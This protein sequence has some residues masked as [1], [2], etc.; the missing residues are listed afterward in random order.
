MP[1]NFL[2]VEFHE[3]SRRRYDL[4]FD[5]A[6]QIRRPL[7]KDENRGEKDTSECDKRRQLVIVHFYY[8]YVGCTT[9]RPILPRMELRL[10]MTFFVPTDL[11]STYLRLL[12]LLLIVNLVL[13]LTE[14]GLF[15]LGAATNHYQ[16]DLPVLSSVD[17]SFAHG[18][19]DYHRLIRQIV[20]CLSSSH[21]DELGNT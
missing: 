7:L 20:L 2:R 5:S 9:S 12:H 4:V 8:S 10:Q 3:P 6:Y 17:L 21:R 11:P 13:Q 16:N 18:S 15:D 14:M 19:T 1:N